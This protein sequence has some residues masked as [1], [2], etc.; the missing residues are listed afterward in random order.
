MSDGENL[1]DY[2][3]DEATIPVDELDDE[4]VGDDETRVKPDEPADDD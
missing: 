4:V 1:P 3:A 2:A